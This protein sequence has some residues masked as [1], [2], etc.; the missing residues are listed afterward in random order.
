MV[1]KTPFL[2]LFSYFFLENKNENGKAGNG[3]ELGNVGI[4]KTKQYERKDAGID[5][6]PG[7]QN[8]NTDP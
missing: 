6:E 1:G 4:S 2:F 5:R 7:T 8:G 3:N